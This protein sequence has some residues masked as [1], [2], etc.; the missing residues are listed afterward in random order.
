MCNMKLGKELEALLAYH[1]QINKVKKV[2]ALHLYFN[3]YK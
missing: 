1:E 3:S 2:N